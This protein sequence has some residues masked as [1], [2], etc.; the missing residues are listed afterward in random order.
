[1][2][3]VAAANGVDSLVIG[4]GISIIDEG[5]GEFKIGLNIVEEKS[6]LSD[7]FTAP[8]P[9]GVTDFLL[10]PAFRPE[11]LGTYLLTVGFNV[12]TGPAIPIVAGP[13]DRAVFYMVDP[14]NGSAAS[15]IPFKIYNTAAGGDTQ[16][17]ILSSTVP[18]QAGKPYNLLLRIYNISGTL[19]AADGF[20]AYSLFPLVSS[21]VEQEPPAPDPGPPG[22]PAMPLMPRRNG[23]TRKRVVI[24]R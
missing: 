18:L 7:I 9:V 21:R 17:S 4:R 13:D 12:N 22:L 19:S 1:M 5:R 16:L 23:F 6:A 8:Y 2:S 20:I 15:C 24:P 10:P 11:F 14:S 3:L